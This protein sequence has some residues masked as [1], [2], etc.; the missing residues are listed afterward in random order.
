MS[1]QAD[2]SPQRHPPSR[3]KP[4]PRPAGGSAKGPAEI[5]A[6]SPATA[7]LEVLLGRVEYL[8]LQRAVAA[9]L[10]N[11]IAAGAP[12]REL[13]ALLQS[14]P[15]AALLAIRLGGAKTS[16]LEE[17]ARTLDP[18]RFRLCLL[19]NS[20][21][22]APE[23]FDLAAFGRQCCRAATV[24][25]LLAGLVPQIDPD[26]AALAGLLADMGQLVLHLCLPKTSRRAAAQAAAGDADL[27]EIQRRL[28]GLDHC[29]AGAR[30]ARRWRLPDWLE[31]VV[32]LH[33][34][35]G[36]T[37]DQLPHRPLVLLVQLAGHLAA[38]PDDQPNSSADAAA[39]AAA[40]GL[41]AQQI[42]QVRSEIPA[43]MEELFRQA[44]MGG[45]G[46][47]LQQVL[48][49]TAQSLQQQTQDL[50]GR[51][52]RLEDRSAELAAMEY[53]LT[54][55][56]EDGSLANLTLALARAFASPAG[57]SPAPGLP[58]AAFVVADGQVMLA[59]CRPGG[60]DSL[61][62]W[63][64]QPAA[65][66]AG[67]SA[68]AVMQKLSPPQF[69]ETQLDLEY[70]SATLLEAPGQAAAGVLL[71]ARQAPAWPML[72]DVAQKI[73]ALCLELS[74]RGRQAE[75]LAAG[76]CQFHRQREAQVSR[77]SLAAVAEMAAGAAHEINNPLAVISGRAQ[78][79]AAKASS[80]QDK[81][82]AEL[83]ARKAQEI[84][85][86]ATELLNFARPPVPAPAR[87]EVA[88]LFDQV[89][90]AV[91]NKN[92]PKTAGARVDIQLQP[93]CPPLW[94][95]PAQLKDVLLELVGNAAQ[96]AGK[97]VT[98]RLAAQP[99]LQGLLLSVSDNGPGM[100]QATLASAFM[101]FFSARPAGRGRGLGL[102]RARRYVE[103][104]GGRIYL[105][106]QPQK[107]TTV[108]LE[109][110]AAGAETS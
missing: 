77:E 36:E 58:V 79:L 83:I 18:A 63:Q 70:Y 82:S 15:A 43:R 88:A 85:D 109:L 37:L 95:D 86:I 40:L 39:L 21:A 29:A 28:M 26:Q 108:F 41:T 5:D 34:L 76:S 22:R 51:L 64:A 69:F 45:A 2:K 20:A 101:P 50:Q 60:D 107:G 6:P 44:A 16:G 56:P 98:V 91:E 106:S 74:R 96:A 55:L 10:L 53:L 24:A 33:H 3:R 80:A 65:L 59:L 72:R 103:A 8:P 12:A 46:Q 27:L 61:R 14:D 68:A 38:L 92:L 7:Q 90:L 84:S 35:P 67:D 97:A 19:E 9:A 71:P 47:D 62:A 78:L 57:I 89:R 81:E 30:L 99:R 4:A 49:G 11:K 1:P 104:N 105:Q 94:A 100:D 42:Q 75:G 52:T 25:R 87:L 48:V 23:G 32:W 102:S 54:N 73:L 110:P 31:Q 93:G 13:A 66:Q 17:T